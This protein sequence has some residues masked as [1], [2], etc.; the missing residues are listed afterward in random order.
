MRVRLARHDDSTPS[1]VLIIYGLITET[2]IKALFTAAFIPGFMLA[3]F[4]IIYIIIRTQLNPT[5][6]PLAEERLSSEIAALPQGDA[7][8][9]QNRT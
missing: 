6:A 7:P 5:H 9:C 2:S 8:E 1:I 4:I 3:S